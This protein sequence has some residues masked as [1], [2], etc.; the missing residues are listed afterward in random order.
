MA[1]SSSKTYER[2]VGLL[3]RA[4]KGWQDKVDA[5]FSADNAS[6]ELKSLESDDVYSK[7][8][9]AS[10]G[11]VLIRLMG[12]MSISIGRRLGELYDNLPKFVA[13]AR[14]GLSPSDVSAKIRGLILDVCIPFRKLAAEDVALAKVA[15]CEALNLVTLPSSADGLGIEIRYNFNPNDNARLRKDVAMAEGLIAANLVPIYLVFSGISPR[16]GA[17]ARLKRA[18]WHFL[19][20]DDAAAFTRKLLGLD[21]SALL[22][23]DDVRKEIEAG[24][25]GVMAA[26]VSS[27]AMENALSDFGR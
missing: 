26:I 6:S 9:L 7:F 23:A 18:G 24:M 27:P 4:I 3:R 25:R 19:I 8:G 14:F 10:N 12:R 16:A 22:D 5:D 13:A 1:E 15:T 20:G 2:F 11:Y 21:L 17:I